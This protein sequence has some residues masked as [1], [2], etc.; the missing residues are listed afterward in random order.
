MPLYVLR[1]GSG[2][3]VWL[4]REAPTLVWGPESQALRFRNKGEARRALARLGNH[5]P[6]KIVETDA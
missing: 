5:R 6:L 1:L 4:K 2:P 3:Y